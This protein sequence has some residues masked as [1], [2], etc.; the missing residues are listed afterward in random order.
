MSIKL[1]S[2]AEG[3]RQYELALQNKDY[4]RVK[5]WHKNFKLLLDHLIKNGYKQS[6]LNYHSIYDYVVNFLK[7]NGGSNYISI[8]Y[9]KNVLDKSWLELECIET[10]SKL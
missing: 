5:I 7:Q 10:L 6:G 3:F 9:I 4:E 2:V 8:T 1:I